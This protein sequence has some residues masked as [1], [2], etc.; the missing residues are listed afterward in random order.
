MGEAMVWQSEKMEP[1]KPPRRTMSYRSLIGLEKA[2][3]YA[4]I[5]E[6]TQARTVGLSVFDDDD[7]DWA[8]RSTS[9]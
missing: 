4:L 1:M 3:L 6:R 8:C 9:R 2:F 7:D 5:P